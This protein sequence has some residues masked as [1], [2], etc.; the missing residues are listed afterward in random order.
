MKYIILNHKMNLYYEELEKYINEINKINKNLIIAPS[1]IY[2]LEFIKNTHHQVSSQDICYID[3]GNYTGKVSWKQIKHLG[4]KYSLIGHSEKHDDITKVNAKLKVCLEHE[5]TPILCF[6][7]T[8][9]EEDITEALNKIN[10]KDINKIIFAY[11]PTFNIGS[12]HIDIDYIKEQIQ[13]IYK[14]LKNKYDKDPIL[15]YGGGINE[16]NINEIYN[17][18]ILKGILI[19]SISSDIEKLKKLLL[20]IDEK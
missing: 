6:G 7:N 1:S 19:G 11:E 17:I 10:I 20:S 14:F 5:L 3:E 15:I 12:N 9:K 8:K 2:L 13:K 18:D 4:I 16:E